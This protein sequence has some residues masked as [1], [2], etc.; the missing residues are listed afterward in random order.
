MLGSNDY[1]AHAVLKLKGI[2][3]I[4]LD[5]HLA[6]KISDDAIVI[7]NQLSNYSNKDLSRGWCDMAIL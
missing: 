7:N 2:D 5:H 4:I 6:D 1:E 3:T